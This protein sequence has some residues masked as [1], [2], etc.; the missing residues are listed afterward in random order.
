MGSRSLLDLRSSTA[1]PGN[2]RARKNSP[3][4]EAAYALLPLYKEDLGNL[5]VLV[6]CDI[7]SYEV[8]IAFTG[9]PTK[10]H[11]FTN[12]DLQNI[13]TREL[14]RQVFTFPKPL[15]LVERQE[16]ITELAAARL[17]QVALTTPQSWLCRWA[18]TGQT[19][20]L[21]TLG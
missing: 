8:H 7:A 18:V 21:I 20:H 15:R 5:P 13:S 1:S 14:L 2:T 3:T 17:A 11:R 16:T 12:A 4:L 10:I 19:T 6:V 9:Y